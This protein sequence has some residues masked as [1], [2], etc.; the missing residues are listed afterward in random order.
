MYWIVYFSKQNKNYNNAMHYFIWGV[1]TWI[2]YTYRYMGTWNLLYSASIRNNVKLHKN[3]LC[4]KKIEKNCWRAFIRWRNE[5]YF[6]VINIGYIHQM[7]AVGIKIPGNCM[8]LWK[9]EK[10]YLFTCEVNR[11]CLCTAV[12]WCRNVPHNIDYTNGVIPFSEK[13]TL[14]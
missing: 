1:I 14:F 10:Q 13:N 6:I 5:V 4:N 7:W 11:Y 9:G 2:T 12:Q 8:L 3:E